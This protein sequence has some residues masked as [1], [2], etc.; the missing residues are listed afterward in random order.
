VRV[1]TWNLYFGAGLEP[2][3]RLRGVEEIPAVVGS[4]WR[5]VRASEPAARMAK[6]AEIVAAGRPDVVALQEVARYEVTAPGEP[7][8]EVVDFLALLLEG[9]RARGADYRAAVAQENFGAALP[10]DDGSLVSFVDRDVVLARAGTATADPRAVR[11]AA[12]ARV[13]PGA[14]FEVPRGFVTVRAEAD[15]VAVRLVNAHLEGAWFGPVQGLQA[16]EL[17]AALAGE[18]LPTVLAGDLNAGPRSLI[19]DGLLA[20]GFEDAWQ[21]GA[22]DGGATCCRGSDLRSGALSAR[23]DLVLARGLAA[24][25]AARLGAAAG[26]RLASGRWPSDHAAVLADLAPGRPP[27]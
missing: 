7:D 13:G 12:R 1:L 27:G 17:L 11:F 16:D 15:G 20:A 6:A 23:I 19:H 9:L 26:D 3:F 10:S 4:L 8:P 14:A 5:A 18:P 25:G 2:V 22:G 24:R 21:A